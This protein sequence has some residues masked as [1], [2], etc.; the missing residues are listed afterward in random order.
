MAVAKLVEQSTRD[1]AES[2]RE[3]AAAVSGA[4]AAAAAREEQWALREREWAARLL[5]MEQLLQGVCAGVARRHAAVV[6]DVDLPLLPPG[7][8]LASPAKKSLAPRSLFEFGALS[9][10]PRDDGEEEI[11]D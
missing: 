8:V 10:F 4:A 5:T 2:R 9:G 1:L 7:L 3:L 11:A 6:D